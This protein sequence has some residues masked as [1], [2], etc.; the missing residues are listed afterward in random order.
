MWHPEPFIKHPIPPTHPP[1]AEEA[2]RSLWF[3]S[4]R[5]G[6]L[7]RSERTWVPAMVPWRATDDGIEYDFGGGGSR[8]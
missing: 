4:F 7:E 1:A 3:S 5:S 8:R 2:A 6:R